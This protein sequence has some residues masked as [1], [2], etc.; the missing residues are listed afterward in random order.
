[1]IKKTMERAH[2]GRIP[3]ELDGAVGFEVGC[4]QSSVGFQDGDSSA[5]IVIGTWEDHKSE[6]RT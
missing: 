3:M 5:A 2:L 4:E 6:S 1:M